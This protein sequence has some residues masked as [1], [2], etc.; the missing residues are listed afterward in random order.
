MPAR[1]IRPQRQ[2][3]GRRWP[4]VGC[5][6]VNGQRRNDLVQL[7]VKPPRRDQGVAVGDFRRPLERRAL[8]GRHA[9]HDASRRAFSTALR[10]VQPG[11]LTHLRG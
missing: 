1:D 5:N 6:N 2:A 8:L 10:L 7:A 11:Y 9:L 3:R 4:V